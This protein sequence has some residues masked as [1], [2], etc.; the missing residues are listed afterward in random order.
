M[1]RKPYRVEIN[2][3]GKRFATLESASAFAAAYWRRTGYILGIEYR[4]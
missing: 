2:G 1:N 4:P 3:R